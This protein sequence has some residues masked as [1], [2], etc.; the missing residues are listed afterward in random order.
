MTVSPSEEYARRLNDREARVAAF[1]KLHVRAGNARLLLA[2]A[3]AVPA[4]ES[5][6]RH[7]I[8]PWWLLLPA[9][10]FVAVGVYHSRVLRAQAQAERAAVVYRQGLARIEDRWQGTGQGGE[11]FD[12]PH[13]VYAA[14][15][16]LFG[17]GS[18]FELLST[19]RTRMGEDALAQWLL[20]PS[21]T[22]DIRERHAA[23]SELRDK[24]DFR[25]ELA[26]LG[27]DAKVGVHPEALRK[28]AGAPNQLNRRRMRWLAP[29]LAVFAVGS[30]VVWAVWGFETPFIVLVVV[31]VLITRSFKKQLT[32]IFHATEHAFANLDLLSALLAR[33]EQEEFAAPRL[34]ILKRQLA[35]HDLAG[36]RAMARLR[37]IVQF[38]ESRR[39]PFLRLI[40]APLMYS[41]QIAFAAEAWR[42]AHGEAAGSW[43][44][45]TGEIEALLSLATYS[46]EHPNDPFPELLEDQAN[47]AA[48]FIGE[49]LGHPLIPAA[50]SVRNSI[51]ICGETRVLLVSGSNMSGKSTLL[52]TVGINA[53][54][55]M[56][57]APVRARR[58]QLT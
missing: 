49:E 16:D 34:L 20:A 3:I 50:R 18:L 17:K 44:D 1:E 54:L 42:S 21:A 37:T 58:L 24:L 28:W 5:I 33:L 56:A 36:S 55:A 32:E 26:V 22:E 8:S 41:V 29:A 4:W 23:V 51:H 2:V 27:E 13:H 19:A 11:R 52:R 48:S 30:A 9:V 35:S 40:D 7:A 10:L 31:E 53:V 46:Y 43:L 38:V 45:V 57:G 39:N 6:V 47:A 12:V 15:L 14:D 25:E